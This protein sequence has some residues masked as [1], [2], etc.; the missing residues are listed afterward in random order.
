MVIS[1]QDYWKGDF[2][3]ECIKDNGIDLRWVHHDLGCGDYN[4]ICYP[5]H[6][7][8]RWRKMSGWNRGVRTGEKKVCL[9]CGKE[10]YAHPYRAKEAKYCSHNCYHIATRK[11][12]NYICKNCG[13]EFEAKTK[14]RIFCSVSCVY[15]Y[16][17]NKPRVATLGNDGYKTV[18][19]SDGS[20]MKEHRYIMEQILG[21]KLDRDEIVH[22]KDGNRANNN[23]DNLVLMT[24][25]EHSKLHRRLELESGKELFHANK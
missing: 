22:H 25:G 8:H 23:I 21:R 3:H 4:D 15:E 16:K 12:N 7:H 19:F 10:F 17:R 14:N 18:W 24:R 5:S 2:R 20:G 6:Q 13:K 1:L 11:P 9:V